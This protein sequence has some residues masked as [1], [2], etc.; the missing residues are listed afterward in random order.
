MDN[1][2]DVG[3]ILREARLAKGLT[4]AEVEKS[5]NIRSYYLE[6]IEDDN[7][8]KTPEE[9]FVKGMI[10]NYGNFLGLDGLE[11]VNI[12]KASKTGSSTENVRSIGIREV[13]KVKLNI[14]LKDKRDM[15]S[16]TGKFEFPFRQ[17]FV[18]F[19]ACLLIAAIYVSMPMITGYF[20]SSDNNASVAAESA[21]QPA[22]AEPVTETS[23]EPEAEAA[24]QPVAATAADSKVVID[25]EAGGN[26]WLEVNADGEEVFAGML[27]MNDRKTYEAQDKLIVK[28]GNTGV[29]SVKVNGVLQD[30]QGEQ[31]VSIKTY[32]ASRSSNG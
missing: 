18:G 15:G 24:P 7:Y 20:A 27:R 14:Q 21:Q 28:Y 2:K 16:G 22:P 11:L 31:G 10:R 19:I 9:V 5:I 4:I 25:I 26:C 3:T 12:Y 32:T 13:D 30:M 29:M 17:F 23:P 6:A 1:T 8:E